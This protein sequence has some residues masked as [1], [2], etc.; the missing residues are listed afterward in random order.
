[1]HV[2]QIWCQ[3]SLAIL[4]SRTRT[5]WH[6]RLTINGSIDACSFS[7]TRVAFVLLVLESSSSRCQVE[8]NL[9]PS[10]D[11]RVRA[12]RNVEVKHG[13]RLAAGSEAAIGP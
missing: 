3:G 13:A 12:E 11:E 8:L 10:N 2:E 6:Y 9:A 4:L 5:S 1:M 7:K